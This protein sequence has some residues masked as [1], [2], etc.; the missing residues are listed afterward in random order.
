MSVAEVPTKRVSP[1][2]SGGRRTTIGLL[3]DTLEDLEE[4]RLPGE[5]WDMLLRRL[6]DQ[7]NRT[8]EER[9]GRK[10]NRTGPV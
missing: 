1:R 5:T 4:K 2:R 10:P 6:L 9:S 7:W 8:K 3:T